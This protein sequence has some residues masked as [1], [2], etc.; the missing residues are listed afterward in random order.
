MVVTRP[1]TASGLPRPTPIFS[2]KQS[3]AA[4]EMLLRSASSPLLNC[5][6]ALAEHGAGHLAVT[7]SPSSAAR[8]GPALMCR[9]MSEGDLAGPL[10]PTAVKKGD[11]HG[12][13]TPLSASSSAS[14]SVVEDVEEEEEEAEYD[15]D[16]VTAGAT[17]P[18][19]LRRLLTTTGLDSSTLA[20]VEQEGGGGKDDSRAPADAHYH[21][22]I[23][24][25]P[26]NPLLL[27][28]YARF[29]KEVQRDAAR[30][31]E[32][33]E[34]AILANPADADALAL[35]AALVWET[36]RDAHRADDYYARAVQAAP[37]DWSVHSCLIAPPHLFPAS[38][39]PD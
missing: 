18:V 37:D 13:A 19:P 29:L 2:R 34:R 4:R 7:S 30:A 25:D 27:G 21:R 3:S 1:E 39:S 12:A 23:D 36:T 16:V 35:Y 26:G 5:A 33:C 8:Q 11:G 9:A 17:A 14:F 20:L 10:V 31:R 22:M 24:A 38:K 32:Y 6:R 28:N 15:D